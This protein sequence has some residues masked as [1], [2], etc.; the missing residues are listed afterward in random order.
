MRHVSQEGILMNCSKS[1]Q[2]RIHDN[3]NAEIDQN[4]EA[5]GGAERFKDTF[6]GFFGKGERE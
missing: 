2:G 6:S 5:D 3:L 1:H 4:Q